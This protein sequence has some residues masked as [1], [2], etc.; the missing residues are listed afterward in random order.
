MWW[1]CFFFFFFFNDTA[2]TEIYTLSLHDALPISMQPFSFPVSCR[3]RRQTLFRRSASWLANRNLRQATAARSPACGHRDILF[4]NPRACTRQLALRS[5]KPARTDARQT[6]LFAIVRW[7][8]T[9]AACAPVSLLPI[10]AGARAR[11]LLRETPLPA[12]V[13]SPGR[14][15]APQ[16]PRDPQ[17]KSR[18]CPPR[19][20][21]KDPLRCA[22]NLLRSGGSRVSLFPCA[23]RLQ[24]F[25][26]VPA[27]DR[28]PPRCPTGKTIRHG[29]WE[30]NALP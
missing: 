8:G 25:P 4:A 13:H 19:R 30:S 12:P 21:R 10:S 18:W 6:K 24:S 7:P 20:S 15:E 5:A 14:A 29:L 3:S 1:C 28:Q 26:P 2:T 9:P 16:I 11:I 17:T 22:A 27:R 23:P